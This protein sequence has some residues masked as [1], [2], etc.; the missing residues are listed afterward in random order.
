[1]TPLAIVALFA[2]HRGRLWRQFQQ[3]HDHRIESAALLP[4]R[5]RPS[6][7]TTAKGSSTAGTSDAAAKIAS[8]TG[9]TTGVT[10]SSSPSV[11][12]TLSPGPAAVYAPITEAWKAY[13][14]NVNKNGGIAGRQIKFNICDD[15]YNPANTVKCLNKLL[16]QDQVFAIYSGLGTPPSNAALPLVQAAGVPSLFINSGDN[17][18]GTRATASSASSPTT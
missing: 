3:I 2:T 5:S 15:G 4:Q 8:I 11:R 1:M 16:Q 12:T 17:K 6:G 18:W 13:F 9:D 14:D 10:D 7:S